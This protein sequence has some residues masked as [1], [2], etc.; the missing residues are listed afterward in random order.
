MKW[1]KSDGPYFIDMPKQD[2][3]TS[4][5]V[6]FIREDTNIYIEIAY[7][8]SKGVFAIQILNSH[9]GEY[10]HNDE[11]IGQHD[12]YNKRL[13]EAL[14]NNGIDQEWMKKN[15]IL[16]TDNSDT[17][18]PVFNDIVLI[19]IPG[20]KAFITLNKI[21][22][23]LE[24]IEGK[25]SLTEAREKVKE[26][27][28][29]YQPSSLLSQSLFKVQKEIDSGNHD[30]EEVA[31]KRLPTDLKERLTFR[32]D[33]ILIA[34]TRFI[35]AINESIEKEGT[36]PPIYYAKENIRYIEN[37]DPSSKYLSEMKKIFK[38]RFKIDY[39][40]AIL[41]ETSPI[42]APPKDKGGGTPGCSVM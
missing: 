10:P 19:I 25:G 13:S 16:S 11:I 27:V 24:E 41:T 22:D 42:S 23:V 3:I 26:W 34:Y 14:K 17:F 4:N 36:P 33:R 39:E 1:E 37:L 38:E 28:P 35:Q 32:E 31:K 21:I 8:Q 12:L 9:N 20:N 30:I 5:Q 18:L 29:K 7:Q 15:T 2:R 40:K 6:V